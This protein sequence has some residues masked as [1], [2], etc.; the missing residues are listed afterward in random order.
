MFIHIAEDIEI[1]NGPEVE[2]RCS[3][4]GFWTGKIITKIRSPKLYGISLGKE[5]TTYAICN[6]CNTEFIL[7]DIPKEF[8]DEN[9]VKLNVSAYITNEVSPLF[10]KLI[11]L[12]TVFC[13][14]MP[15]LPFIIRLT[16]RNELH[17]IKGAWKYLYRL[18]LPAAILMHIIFWPLV[19]LDI[20]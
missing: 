16:V 8:L 14:M 12:L 19:F 2:F 17:Y 6:Q 20:I 18:T 11:I 4:C 13:L 5:K 1:I 9:N 7:K 10:P 15:I 3:S